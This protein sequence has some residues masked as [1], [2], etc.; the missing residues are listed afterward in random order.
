[1]SIFR[2]TIL[3]ITLFILSLNLKAQVDFDKLSKKAD[4]DT[5]VYV[6][7]VGGNIHVLDKN[8]CLKGCEFGLSVDNLSIRLQVINNSLKVSTTVIN[9][10]GEVVIDVRNS[11][12]GRNIFDYTR[13][14]DDSAVELID[15]SQIVWF[16]MRK[17]KNRIYINGIFIG[18]RAITVINDNSMIGYPKANALETKNYLRQAGTIKKIFEYKGKDAYHKRVVYPLND[19]LIK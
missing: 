1:M 7:H 2:D 12:Y 17:D 16:N 6:V 15:K 3:L 11:D 18:E 5:S 14:Y 10:K 4:N 13:N 19:K 8:E 9:E